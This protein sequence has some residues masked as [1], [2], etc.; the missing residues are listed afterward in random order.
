MMSTGPGNPADA[1]VVPLLVGRTLADLP[2]VAHGFTTREGGV[3]VGPFATLN[4]ARREGEADAALA[5]N[6]ARTLRALDPRL[7]EVAVAHQVHGRD[8]IRVERGRGPLDPLGD[9]DALVTTI[10]GVVLAVRVADCVPVLLAAPGGVAAA[11]A[12]WRGTVAGVVE[13]ALDALCEATGADP[14]AVVAA[15]GPHIGGTSYEVGPE[16]I[17]GLAATGLPED[18]WRR[19]TPGRRDRADLGAAVEAQLRRLGVTRVDR[20][21]GD[22]FADPRFFSHRRDGAGTGRMVGAIARLP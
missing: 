18:T 15:V 10:P 7:A 6:W 8:V 13:V 22:T 20:V 11:H 12:G 17:E 5:T 16:V 21:A 2:G 4:L 19:R 9:A 1:G 3:S 14:G